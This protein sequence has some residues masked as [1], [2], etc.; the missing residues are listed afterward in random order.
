MFGH[1]NKFARTAVI[2]QTVV[3]TVLANFALSPVG[4]TYVFQQPRIKTVAGQH[5]DINAVINLQCQRT[6]PELL[7]LRPRRPGSHL[8][9]QSDQ[10]II[11]QS[12]LIFTPLNLVVNFVITGS[13]NGTAD[14]AQLL[15]FKP[16]LVKTNLCILIA[17]LHTAFIQSQTSQ[18]LGLPLKRHIQKV[19]FFRKILRRDF[20]VVHMLDN[21][22]PLLNPRKIFV[23]CRGF[24]VNAFDRISL[25]KIKSVFFNRFRQV[26]NELGEFFVF[27]SVVD[28]FVLRR[29]KGFLHQIHL[30]GSI[31]SPVFAA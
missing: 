16:Q 14:F 10:T 28:N 23:H 4:M 13:F 18:Q 26:I 9:H 22:L 31:Q 27:F 21:C 24:A 19:I 25:F 29:I 17:H 7:R 6:F 5:F 11:L 1:I 20:T 3:K 30:F 2:R 8:P 15:Q 12:H